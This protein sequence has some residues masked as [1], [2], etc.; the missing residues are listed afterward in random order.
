MGLQVGCMANNHVSGD[1]M[2]LRALF[3]LVVAASLQC[4]RILLPKNNYL[5]SLRDTGI[6][7]FEKLEFMNVGNYVPGGA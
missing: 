6:A 1:V 4:N 2:V 7:S 5:G 3:S